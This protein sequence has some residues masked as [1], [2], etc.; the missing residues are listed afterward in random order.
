MHAHTQVTSVHTHTD[1]HK[2]TATHE[3]TQTHTHTHTTCRG[4]QSHVDVFQDNT[5][6]SAI[7]VLL[8]KE[9]QISY[10]ARYAQGF[11]SNE[12]GKGNIIFSISG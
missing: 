8:S 10:R 2:H 12:T 5:G 3:H 7:L 1:T 9:G 4:D 6:L 11:P